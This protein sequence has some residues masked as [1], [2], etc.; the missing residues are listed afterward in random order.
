MLLLRILLLVL[1]VVAAVVVAALA[2]SGLLAAL[3]VVVAIAATAATTLLMLHYLGA[4]SWLGAGPQDELERASLVEEETGL[5]TRRRWNERQAREYADEVAR[6][7][8][9]AVPDGWRGPDGAHRILLVATTPVDADTLRQVLGDAVSRDD[10]AV[11]VVVPA[12][13]A[14]EA[15]FRLGDAAEAVEHAERIARETVDRLR[16]AGVHVTG[17]IGPAD[18]AVAVSDGLRTYDAE[19]VIVVRRGGD[20]RYLEDVPLHGAAEAFG[21]PLKEVTAAG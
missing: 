8:L 11:L 19:Q 15:R 13:A 6:R 3:A 9:V 21:V 18:P 17:H 16:A 20:R 10:L 1:V 14:T 4:P 7:G 2:D 5:P 12:L